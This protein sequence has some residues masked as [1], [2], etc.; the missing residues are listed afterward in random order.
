MPG[1]TRRRCW[2]RPRRRSSY[3][4]STCWCARSRPGP[5]VGVGTYYR[6]FPTPA[7]LI[8]AV[9]RHQVE[10]CAE[11]CLVLLAQAGTPHHA[12]ARRIGM[13]VDFLVTK[14]G[15]AERATVRRRGLPDPARLLHRPLG[16]GGGNS[17]TLPPRPVRSAPAWMPT[18]GPASGN[19]R[20]G[21]QRPALQPSS[22]GRTPHRRTAH[23]LGGSVSPWQSSLGQ[24]AR[25]AAAPAPRRETR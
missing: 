7:D 23:P 13:F 10:A 5:G 3:P 16:P 2:T 25:P 12:L 15:L 4:A 11:A 14:H 20:R 22:P 24:F 9:Y 8:V 21:G 6:H 19:L 18:S 1:G 17:L